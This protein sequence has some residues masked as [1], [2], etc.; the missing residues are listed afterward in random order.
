MAVIS[1]SVDM[2]SREDDI[3]LSFWL[4]GQVTNLVGLQCREVMLV[5]RSEPCFLLSSPAL[6]RYGGDE[7]PQTTQ[8]SNIYRAG[9]VDRIRETPGLWAAKKGKKENFILLVF[10]LT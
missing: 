9:K 5:S 6:A 3:S 7:R 1:L 2:K 4:S 8:I 10:N